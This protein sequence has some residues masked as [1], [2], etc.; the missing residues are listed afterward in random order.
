M[1][2]N[3]GRAVTARALL[4]ER[5]VDEILLRLRPTAVT[6]YVGMR[7]LQRRAGAEPFGASVAALEALTGLSEPTIIQ[8][9]RLLQGA[10]LIAEAEPASGRYV[11]L[12]PVELDGGK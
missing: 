1:D 8:A 3:R 7:I 2:T 12:T 4:M 5:V 6:V 11:L 9:R 10:G